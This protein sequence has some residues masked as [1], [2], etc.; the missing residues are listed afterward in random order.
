MDAAGIKS[1][2]KGNGASVV[3]V[4]S[5]DAGADEGTRE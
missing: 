3:G 4:A 2:L 5:V 1:F